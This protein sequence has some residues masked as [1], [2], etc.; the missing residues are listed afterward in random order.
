MLTRSGLPNRVPS[1]SMYSREGSSCVWVRVGLKR[2]PQDRQTEGAA[3]KAGVRCCSGFSGMEGRGELGLSEGTDQ[4]RGTGRWGEGVE[5]EG[6]ALVWL[7]K[8]S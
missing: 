8:A 4:S 1:A 5:V 3:G 7:T 6:V 2:E